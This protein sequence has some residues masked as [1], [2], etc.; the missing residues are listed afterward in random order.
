[1]IGVIDADGLAI[2]TG[3]HQRLI[4]DVGRRGLGLLADYAASGRPSTLAKARQS[5]ASGTAWSIRVLEE[6][7]QTRLRHGFARL[8]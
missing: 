7:D 3:H 5:V 2:K 8:P 4:A 1:L 6:I